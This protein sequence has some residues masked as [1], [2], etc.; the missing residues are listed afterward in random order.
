MF[1]FRRVAQAS[2][3]VA[4]VAIAVLGGHGAAV[5]DGVL[6]S[7]TG[8]GDFVGSNGA[9]VTFSYSAIKHGDGSVSGQYEIHLRSLDA[10]FQGPVTCF[11]VAGNHGW[12][13]G[14]A[15]RVRSSNPDIAA[16]EGNDMW[17]QVQDNGQGANDPPD[18]TTSIGVTP[19]GG[20]PGQAQAY[21]DAMR[22]PVTFHPVVHGNI[23]VRDDR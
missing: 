17:F 10:V 20:P 7:V 11:S 9:L 22:P 4:L 15:E 18:L 12:V 14:I 3:C 21:C 13:G 23:Q 1:R 2:C 19:V 8:S 16:L 6:Q 5:A